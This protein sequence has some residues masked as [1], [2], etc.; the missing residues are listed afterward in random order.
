MGSGSHKPFHAS[1]I[2]ADIALKLESLLKNAEQRMIY[3]Y[4]DFKL[5]MG[6]SVVSKRAKTRLAFL[7]SSTTSPAQCLDVSKYFIIVL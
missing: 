4:L 3:S 6:P 1:L 5:T 7:I 2:T